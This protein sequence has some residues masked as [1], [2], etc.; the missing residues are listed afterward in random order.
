MSSSYNSSDEEFDLEEEENILILL[1]IHANKK[2]KHGGSVFGR[3]KLWRERMDAHNRL[4]R[5]YFVDNPIYPDPYFQCRFRM[6][7]EL[8][9][10]I[11]DELKRHDR[12]VEQRKN[13]AGE[14]GHSTY[15][16]VT[17]AL[18]MVAYGIPADLV[19]D[20]LQWV[21]VKPSSV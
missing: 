11:V 17:A 20:H 4:M 7:I 19:D 13:A 3:Q 2:P 8:F 10:R 21:R 12:F 1:A 9:K 15:Q 5:N 14:L 16:K 18:R 6:S